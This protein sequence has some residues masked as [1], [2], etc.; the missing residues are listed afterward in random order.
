[1]RRDNAADLTT[2]ERSGSS[3]VGTIS[4]VLRVGC[5]YSG[6]QG[7]ERCVFLWLRDLGA[8]RAHGVIAYFAASFASTEQANGTR[9]QHSSGDI[10]VLDAVGWCFVIAAPRDARNTGTGT[11]QRRLHGTCLPGLELTRDELEQTRYR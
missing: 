5:G 11:Q 2:F 10:L 8:P 9:S 7:A 1:M 3:T 6:R 4:H